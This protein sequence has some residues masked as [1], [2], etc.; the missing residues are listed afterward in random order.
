ML[1]VI[2]ADFGVIFVLNAVV[3]HEQLSAKIAALLISR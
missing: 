3:G 2:A 1:V